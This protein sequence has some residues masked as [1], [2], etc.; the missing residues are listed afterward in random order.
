[1]SGFGYARIKGI[2]NSTDKSSNKLIKA[3]LKH[4]LD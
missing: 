2:E 4:Y 1:M 3:T